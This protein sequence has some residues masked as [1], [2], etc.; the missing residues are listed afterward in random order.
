MEDKA[1]QRL[2]KR[3]LQERLEKRQAELQ[4]VKDA[5]VRWWKKL[6]RAANAI[7][8]LNAEEKRLLAPRKLGYP[9]AQLK[10]TG[11]QWHQIR[12]D[13]ELNDPVNL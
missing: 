2:E 1:Q 8:K 3:K 11:K 4:R 7:E 10:V 13:V 5:K 12:K 9:E 6:M